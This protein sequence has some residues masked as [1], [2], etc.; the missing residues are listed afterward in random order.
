MIIV[1]G[2]AGFIGSNLVAGLEAAGHKRIVVCDTLGREDKWKNIAK[3]RLYNIIPPH[4]LFEYLD[5]H[6]LDVEAIFHMGAISATTEQDVDLIIETNFV[7]SRALWNW[8]ARNNTRFIYSSSAATYGDNSNGFGDSDD[9]EFLARL[10]PLNPYGWSKHLVDRYVAGI[11]HGQEE[12]GIPPQWC[13]LKFFNVYGPNERHKGDQM[14]VVSKLYPQI[15]AGAAARLFKSHSKDYADG[16]QLRD[17]IYVRDCVK[18]MLWLYDNPQVCGLFNV[19]T[20]L[21][22]SFRDLAAATFSAAGIKEK[23]NYIDMP[24]ELKNRYQYFTQADM[25]KLRASGYAEPFF[26][27]EDGVH[28]YVTNFLSTSDPYC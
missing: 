26:S 11:V 19:G 22:R 6:A 25:G 21:A 12:G 3:R 4:R 24:E 28:D 15:A 2:G 27:L 9:P 23:I 18:I 5:D 1:T 7:L 8:C 20:G 10:R 16:G 17:F 13:G 14:S